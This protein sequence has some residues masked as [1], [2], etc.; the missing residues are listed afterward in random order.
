MSF[1]N[2]VVSQP[3]ESQASKE[4]SK[5]YQEHAKDVLTSA[6]FEELLERSNKSL[7][8]DSSQSELSRKANHIVNVK[9]LFF[10]I[11]SI[12]PFV[13]LFK[14][15]VYKRYDIYLI[16]T[17]VFLGTIVFLSLFETAFYVISFILL[18]TL[19]MIRRKLLEQSD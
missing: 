3:A 11:L 9:I 17:A 12:L 4:Y 16:P 19:S 14:F 5:Y 2:S 6:E 8:F 18:M 10:T 7:D 15:Y 13:L 1:I